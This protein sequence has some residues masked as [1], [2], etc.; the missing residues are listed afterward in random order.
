MI[1][2]VSL[3]DGRRMV[4]GQGV[5]K[6][7]RGVHLCVIGGDGGDVGAIDWKVPG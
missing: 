5:E 2:R 3:S 7:S 1:E 6:W 4:P